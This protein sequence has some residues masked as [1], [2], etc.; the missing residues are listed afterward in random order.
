MH[1]LVKFTL[2]QRID[3]AMSIN[4]AGTIEAG[5]N[6]DN[7]EMGLRASQNAMIRA[8]V[9]HFQMLNI[10]CLIECLFNTLNSRFHATPLPMIRASDYR[11]GQERCKAPP[12][13]ADAHN[14]L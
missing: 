4:T 6:N 3:T 7:L 8:L 1:T 9:N 2:Q 5:R 14:A 10:Q 11:A 12:T 13:K